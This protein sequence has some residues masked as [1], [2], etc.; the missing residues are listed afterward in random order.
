VIANSFN[1]E[2]TYLMLLDHAP[3]ITLRMNDVIITNLTSFG[4][5]M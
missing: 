3:R 5:S 4:L 2:I 1:N